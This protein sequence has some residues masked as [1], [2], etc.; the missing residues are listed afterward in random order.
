[1]KYKIITG[2]SNDSQILASV[3]YLPGCMKHMITVRAVNICNLHSPRSHPY[4][5][6][7][8]PMACD[9]VTTVISD[10]GGTTHAARG[11]NTNGQSNNYI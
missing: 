9:T 2:A 3:V 1:M 4:P 8:C 7:P 11:G 6:E 10:A 5:L